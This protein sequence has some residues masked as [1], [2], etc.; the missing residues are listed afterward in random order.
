MLD[1]QLEQY[2]NERPD[3][4]QA[5]CH[6][7]KISE[8]QNR[9]TMKYSDLVSCIEAACLTD[10]S[11]APVASGPTEFS[12]IEED[13]E[14]EDL[15][16]LS[17]PSTFVDPAPVATIEVDDENEQENVEPDVELPEDLLSQ[18]E[19]SEDSLD[20]LLKKYDQEA[21]KKR[22]EQKKQEKSK[23]NQNII[24]RQH[25]DETEIQ[26]I[27]ISQSPPL[28]P[29][30]TFASPIST[31]GRGSKLKKFKTFESGRSH[32][33][34]PSYASSPISKFLDV[35]LKKPPL[36]AVGEYGDE[37]DR[38]VG[39]YDFPS[40]I[41][42][43]TQKTD[44]PVKIA[45]PASSLAKLVKKPSNSKLKSYAKE[46]QIQAAQSIPDE[47]DDEVR[48]ISVES[49]DPQEYNVLLLVDQQEML[50]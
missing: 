37:F 26:T 22:K 1:E 33:A 27:D 49:I 15:S 25:K 14:M 32:L 9:E 7:D 29:L 42:V 46:T 36:S 13:S 34:G 20:R 10:D 50:G 45:K 41:P 4:N 18:S 16:Q 43:V 31:L 23:E 30:K 3:L 39:K 12:I 5:L 2:L 8:L 44:L 35:E 40:P 17:L 11:Y 24:R 47:E 28:S 6:K 48:Y 19:D 21:A 38:L